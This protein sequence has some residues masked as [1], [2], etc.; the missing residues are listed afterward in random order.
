MAT[1]K[2]TK[3]QKHKKKEKEPN[4]QI[5]PKKKNVLIIFKLDGEVKREREREGQRNFKTF[6][7]I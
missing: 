2:E 5:A 6:Q 3:K 1:M 4:H 7:E